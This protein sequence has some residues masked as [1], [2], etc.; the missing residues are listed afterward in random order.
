MHSWCGHGPMY[1]LIHATGGLSYLSPSPEMSQL[2][3]WDNKGH[4]GYFFTLWNTPGESFPGRGMLTMAVPSCT[5]IAG[6]HDETLLKAI[7][8]TATICLPWISCLSLPDCGEDVEEIP[9]ASGWK[10]PKRRAFC[11]KIEKFF[12]LNMQAPKPLAASSS[13]FSTCSC[14]TLRAV[15]THSYPPN[16][17]FLCI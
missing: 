7:S 10:A 6:L 8:F 14:A 12:Q 9:C 13:G 2:K 4:P 1:S 11:T 16:H 5:R 17:P 15:S 3:P